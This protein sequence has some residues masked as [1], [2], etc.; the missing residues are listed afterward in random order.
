MGL[1][2]GCIQVWGR[3]RLPLAYTYVRVFFHNGLDFN[4]SCADDWKLV[5]TSDSYELSADSS[6]GLEN[7]I[8]HRSCDYYS[9][10]R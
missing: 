3:D 2:R 6:V 8:Y 5:S 1:I 9:Q 4:V 10:S 7:L